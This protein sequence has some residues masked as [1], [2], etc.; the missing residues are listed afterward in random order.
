MVSKREGKKWEKR[1][2]GGGGLRVR[3]GMGGARF[4]NGSGHTDLR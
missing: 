4:R 1:G 2:G 3:K